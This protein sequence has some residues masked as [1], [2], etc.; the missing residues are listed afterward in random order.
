MRLQ[1]K[2][3]LSFLGIVLLFIVL[4]LFIVKQLTPIRATSADTA[5][6]TEDAAKSSTRK[7]SRK[8]PMTKN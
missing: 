4:N 8:S 3:V 1:T 7:R 2:L 6:K 5:K